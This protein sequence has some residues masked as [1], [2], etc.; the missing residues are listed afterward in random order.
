MHFLPQSK[1][2][3]ILLFSV[4]MFICLLC[5]SLYIKQKQS[6]IVALTELKIAEQ[7]T[8]LSSIALLTSKDGAD[9]VVENIIKDCSPEY[10]ARFDEQLSQLQLLRGQQLVEMDQLFGA[11]GNFF[12]ERKAVM[13][14]RLEREFEVY[15]NLIEI[16]TVADIRKDQTQYDQDSW[17]KLVMMEKNRS[18]LSLKLVEIQG[19]IITALRTNISLS[20]DSMQNLLVDGQKTKESLVSLSLEIDTL[21]QEILNL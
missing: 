1:K 12:A 5:A 6:Q 11:C 10:R 13:V 18:E 21:T 8:T 20:S 19:D 7:E 15:K 16:L 17:E 14:A 3:I 4:G 9:S 2:K